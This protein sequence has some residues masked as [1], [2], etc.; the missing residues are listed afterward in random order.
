MKI[1]TV[2]HPTNEV[3]SAVVIMSA[4]TSPDVT[5]LTFRTASYTHLVTFMESIINVS[6]LKISQDEFVIPWQLG[7][8]QFESTCE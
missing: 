8:Q 1:L 4:V 6:I 5:G 3:A 2:G 7:M